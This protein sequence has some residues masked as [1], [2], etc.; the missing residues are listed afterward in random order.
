MILDEIVEYK[1]LELQ[2]ARDKTPFDYLVKAVSGM[3]PPRDF[4]GFVKSTDGLEIIAEVKK[5]SPSKGVISEN[6]D[7]VR[8]ARDYEKAGAS[9][10]SVLTDEKFFMGSLEYLSAV[11]S[12]VTVP[13]LRKDFTIDPYHIYEARYYGADIV[14]L[15]VSILEKKQLHEFI[16]I[17]RQLGMS[18]IVEVHDEG[19]LDTALEAGSRIVGINNRDLKTFEVDISTTERLSD[20]IPDDVVIISESG[21]SGP[22][23][24]IRLKKK[25]INV[26]LIGESFMKTDDPGAALRNLLDSVDQRQY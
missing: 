4:Y 16:G 18:A 1:K 20:L 11:K 2:S 13:V 25:G 10:I 3:E 19:E 15:I 5:A 8:I 6:F 24:I 7:P 22:E 26:F 14:L 23:N 17:T 9:A 12:N 21:I